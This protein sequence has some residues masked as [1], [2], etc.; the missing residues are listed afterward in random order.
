MAIHII[1]DS[2]ADMTGTESELLTVI[3]LTV[4]FGNDE[5]KDGETLS[6]TEFYEKLVQCEALPITSQITPYVYEQAILPHVENGEKVIVITLSGKLSGTWQNA[7]V[8]A[9]D[10]P[11]QV[12]VVDS[13]NASIGQRI[14]VECAIRLVNEGKTVDEVVTQLNE[15]KKRIHFVA[16]L[17]TLEY[18]QKGGRI[19]KV[20]AVAGNLLS[21]KPVIAIESGEVSVLGKARGFKQGKNMMSK[22]IEEYG[23]IDTALPCHFAYT[24]LDDAQIQMYR[25]ENA[26]RWQ[27][28]EECIP[29][30]IV[31]CAIGTHIGPG[32]IGV[33][34]V[35]K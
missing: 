30:S 22:Q 25:S 21:I 7:S 16:V 24:G 3:P 15:I 26:Y 9:E 20:A 13:E 5:Y 6:R 33:A 14:L 27:K 12:Y 11:N 17:D 1:T 31:G 2:A 19:S 29:I 23:E 4:L 18:L 32:A 10:Y 8:L 35:E 34:W 28:E